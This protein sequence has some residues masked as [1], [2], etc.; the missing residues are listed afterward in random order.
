MI[1]R[2][3]VFGRRCRNDIGYVSWIGCFYEGGSMSDI[4]CVSWRGYI[5]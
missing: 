3:C 4:H 1:G 5:C 2:V